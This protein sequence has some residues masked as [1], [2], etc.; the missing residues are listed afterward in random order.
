MKTIN[1]EDCDAALQRFVETLEKTEVV[2]LFKNG[3]PRYVL[4]GID[5]FEWEVFSLSRNQA[6]M[7]YLEQ[8]RQRGKREGTIPIEEVR[9]RL[10]L[11]ADKNGG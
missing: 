9:Q 7:D 5:D 1:L 6:F 4:G 2:I 3:Q 10:G 11:P 8:A